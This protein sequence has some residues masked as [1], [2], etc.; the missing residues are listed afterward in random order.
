MLGPDTNT[1]KT[2][3]HFCAVLFEFE[4]V[5]FKRILGTFFQNFHQT[6][7]D[8]VFWFGPILFGD[9]VWQEIRKMALVSGFWV[10]F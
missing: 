6:F 7:L 5:A 8:G 2:P 9:I 1:T 10:Y 4:K 3:S